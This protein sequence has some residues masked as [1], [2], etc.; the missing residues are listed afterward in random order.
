[1]HVL[2]SENVKRN[3]LKVGS[4]CGAIMEAITMEQIEKYE[5]NPM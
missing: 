2:I 4:A 3:L 5:S 1:M